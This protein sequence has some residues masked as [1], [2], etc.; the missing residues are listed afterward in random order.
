[1]TRSPHLLVVS[2]NYAESR[3][4]V[5]EHLQALVPRLV[6]R[7]VRVTLGYLGSERRVLESGPLTVESLRPR[8]DVKGVPPLPD[9]RHWRDFARRA[10]P[11]GVTHVSTRTRFFPLSWMGVQWG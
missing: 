7:G 3:G 4:G 1:M 2:T 9:P 10:H 8:A 5:E 6:D 11:G